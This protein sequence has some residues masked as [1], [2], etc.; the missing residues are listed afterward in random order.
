MRLYIIARHGES[1]FNVQRR[2]NGDPAVPVVLTELGR[3]QSRRLGLQLRGLPIDVCWVSRFR[4]AQETAALVLEGR[5]VPVREDARLD[6]LGV[7]E[8]EGKHA[9]AHRDWRTSHNRNEAPSG[10]ES[11]EAARLRYVQA[12]DALAAQPE[13]VTLVLGHEL[14]LR[15]LLNSATQSDHLDRPIHQIANATP[16]LFEESALINALARMRQLRD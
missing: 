4:R 11:L 16:Y 3:S 9:D 8:L 5:S 13:P 12:F 6:D 7:G 2:I 1:T 15:Y 14:A 10:G